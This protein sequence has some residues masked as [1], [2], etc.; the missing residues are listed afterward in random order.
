MFGLMRACSCHKTSEERELQRLHYCGTCKTM[1][2]LYGQKSRLFLNYDAVFLGELLTDLQPGQRRFAPAYV[3]KN[4]LSLPKRDQIPLALEY[5]AA[6]NV[7]LAQFKLLDH[8]VDTGSKLMH[9][10]VRSYSEEFRRASETLARS[11]FPF[12]QLKALMALQVEREHETHPTMKRVAE[13][14]M[15]ATELVFG[16]G[17]LAIGAAGQSS[18]MAKLGRVFGEIAYIVDAIEDEEKDAEKGAFNALAATGTSKEQAMDLLGEQRAAML[19]HLEALPIKADRKRTFAQRLDTN[20]APFLFMRRPRPDQVVYVRRERGPGFCND[21]CQA[22]CCCETIQ[23]CDCC[24]QGC[25]DCACMG[26][27]VLR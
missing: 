13:P 1:G 19:R 24:G 18:T 9:L 8:V 7:V 5:A 25:C 15:G 23:C 20:L 21:C 26:C 6:A 4:C 16:H 3:S 10:A 14:T 2:R 27:G 11:R 22:I 12:E 17:A